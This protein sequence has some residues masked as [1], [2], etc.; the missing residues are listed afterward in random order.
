[1]PAYGTIYPD[2]NQSLMFRRAG[3]QLNSRL[4]IFCEHAKLESVINQQKHL[5]NYSV[6]KKTVLLVMIVA[7]S[8]GVTGPTF[9]QKSE[10]KQKKEEVT[11]YFKLN[12]E[13]CHNCKR[14]IEGYLPFEKG[15]TALA[16]G[17]DPTTVKVTYRADR[18]DTLKLQ[19]AFHKIKLE[20]VETRLGQKE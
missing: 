17:D 11:A 3:I 8:A 12:E 1:M 16:Y 10:Q 4:T 5:K 2:I 15:V 13:I 7:L 6:M 20:V 18:T 19:K 9:A 14:K